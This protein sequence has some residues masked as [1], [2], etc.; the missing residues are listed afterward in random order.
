MNRRGFTGAA[1][2]GLGGFFFS[3]KTKAICD[4]ITQYDLGTDHI[5][6]RYEVLSKFLRSCKYEYG[7]S[8]VL[9]PNWGILP[10]FK[11]CRLGKT[12]NVQS[13]YEDMIRKSSDQY[14]YILHNSQENLWG[15]FSCDTRL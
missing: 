6:V 14:V 9:F 8:S 10:M 12:G 1:L 3:R 4:E 13:C 5:V 2:A 7:D 15:F 11:P